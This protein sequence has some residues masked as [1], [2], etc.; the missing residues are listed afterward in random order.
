MSVACTEKRDFLESQEEISYAEF[1]PGGFIG[2]H[3]V[4][5]REEFRMHVISATLGYLRL[6]VVDR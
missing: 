1:P 4:Q 5:D 3:S 6:E 2:D